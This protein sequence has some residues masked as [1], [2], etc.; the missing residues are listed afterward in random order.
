MRLAGYAT[1]TGVVSQAVQIHSADW[2]IFLHILLEPL[3]TQLLEQR[4]PTRL[5]NDVH[6]KIDVIR[7]SYLLKGIGIRQ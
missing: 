4:V 2:T 6:D 1:A 3:A 7:M 5:T